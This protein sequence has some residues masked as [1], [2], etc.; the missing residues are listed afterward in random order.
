MLLD[1]FWW[2]PVAPSGGH[3]QYHPWIHGRAEDEVPAEVVE[4]AKEAVKTVIQ[5]RKVANPQV[6]QYRAEVEFR[7]ALEAQKREWM[8]IYIRVLAKLFVEIEQERED[9]QIAMLLFD[10]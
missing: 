4:Q 2:R 5:G 3:P 10:M 1:Y 6:D 8:S 7:K 9:A